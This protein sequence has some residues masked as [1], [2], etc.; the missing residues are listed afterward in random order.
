MESLMFSAM[1]RL[2][3]ALSL[4]EKVRTPR[5]LSLPGSDIFNNPIGRIAS[6]F[7][8]PLGMWEQRAVI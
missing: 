8:E 1:L 6:I 3:R 2:P 4:K 5:T 7:N